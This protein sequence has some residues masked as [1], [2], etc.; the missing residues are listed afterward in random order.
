MNEWMNEI[1]EI[2][3][4]SLISILCDVMIPFLPD[5][6]DESV[7]WV[8]GAFLRLQLLNGDFDRDLF[9]LCSLDKVGA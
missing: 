9:A 5:I 2:N 6:D 3:E 4:W 7:S 8:A 1:N